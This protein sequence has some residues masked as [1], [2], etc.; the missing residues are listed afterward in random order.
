MMHEEPVTAYPLCWPRGQGRTPGH[1]RKNATFKL[2]KDRVERELFAEIGRMGG[3]RVVVSTMQALNQQGLPHGG[4]AAPS[5]PAVA[6]YFNRKGRQVCFACD[7]YTTITDNLRAVSL[8]IEALRG[9]ER[10]GGIELM[11]RAFTGFAALPS[12]VECRAPWYAVLGVGPE[13]TVEGI[14]EARLALAKR[15]H[16]D[17]GSEPDGAKMAEINGAADEGLKYARGN[18]G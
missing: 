15:Y 6:V 16:P 9:I 3:K 10:W 13:A 5:D 4:R 8:T 7:K 18:G 14:Q 12:P 11:D 17:S 2:S 1:Q